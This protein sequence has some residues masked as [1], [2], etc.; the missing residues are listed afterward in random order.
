MK[1]KYKVIIK[2][3]DQ[4]VLCKLSCRHCYGR[5]YIG[6]HKDQN[7]K[8]Q[9]RP[10]SCLI[11]INIKKLN[12]MELIELQHKWGFELFDEKEKGAKANAGSS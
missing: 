11:I 3:A 9:P 5:S 10:C 7:G 12:M 1:I 4:V 6:F 2:T 8:K